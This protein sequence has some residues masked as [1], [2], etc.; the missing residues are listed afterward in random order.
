MAKPWHWIIKDDKTKLLD[1]INHFNTEIDEA[2]KEVKKI[3]SVEKLSQD[4]P[5]WH[6]TRL[7]QLQELEAVLETLE[8]EMKQI[9]GEK[10]KFFLESYRRQLSST[11]IKKYVEGDKDVC[12]LAEVINEVAFLRNQ[13]TSIVKSLEMKAFQLNNIVKLRCA[14]LEDIRLN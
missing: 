10:F 7:S 11:D 3:G 14:G 5:G 9:Q 8:I 13:Y 4:L 6:E 1:L 2:K 12:D